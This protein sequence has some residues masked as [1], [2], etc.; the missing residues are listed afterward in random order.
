M[1]L[2]WGGDSFSVSK[3]SSRGVAG[4]L[5][6][7]CVR[8]L[9]G[10]EGCEVKPGS[11]LV[12]SLLKKKQQQQ[13][14]NATSWLRAAVRSKQVASG[15]RSKRCEFPTGGALTG[16][17]DGRTSHWTLKQLGRREGHACSRG[18][19]CEHWQGCVRCQILTIVPTL[20]D[21]EAP[22]S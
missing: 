2:P 4:G 8:M 10:S 12:W 3:V 11:A 18:R 16:C 13:P 1:F 5:S 22:H 19:R 6:W 14:R 15:I 7:L 17:G 21:P 9:Y 20:C